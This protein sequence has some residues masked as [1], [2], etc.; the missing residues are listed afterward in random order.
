MKNYNFQIPL[1]DF[2][3]VTAIFK[4]VSLSGFLGKPLQVGTMSDNSLMYAFI[5]FLRRLS[6]S[7][8]FSLK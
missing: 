4:M 6:I 8:W 5:L 2:I 7:L 1:N 3:Y